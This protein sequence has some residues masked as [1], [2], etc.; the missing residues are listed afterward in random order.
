[1]HKTINIHS[2]RPYLTRTSPH[3]TFHRRGLE[4]PPS[5]H[6][7]R[8]IVNNINII[9]ARYNA[10]GFVF[11]FYFFFNKCAIVSTVQL[12][13]RKNETDIYIH[14]LYYNCCARGEHYYSGRRVHIILLL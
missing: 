12:S 1:M 8:I 3:R 11:L 14:T 7:C 9:I 6:H 2:R 4:K 13:R 10:M 5:H